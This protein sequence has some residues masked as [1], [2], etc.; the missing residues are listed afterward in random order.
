MVVRMARATGYYSAD[1]GAAHQVQVTD[2][3]HELVARELVGKRRRL[4]VVVVKDNQ[5]VGRQR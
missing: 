3:V 2:Q 4:A 5:R 1:K